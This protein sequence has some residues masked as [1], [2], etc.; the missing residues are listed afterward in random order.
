VNDQ[1]ATPRRLGPDFVLEQRRRFG[2]YPPEQRQLTY[3]IAVNNDCALWRQWLGDQLALLPAHIADAMARR[4]WLDE[5][6]WPVNF[7]LATSAGLRAV[8]LNA[9]RDCATEVPSGLRDL[10]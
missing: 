1:T 3:H 2:K 5:H 6:F 4:I 10:G 9:Q 7:E 8:G